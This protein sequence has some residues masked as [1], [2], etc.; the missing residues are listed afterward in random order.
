MSAV[1]R[2]PTWWLTADED[3]EEASLAADRALASLF[4][5]IE[6]APPPSFAR[7]ALVASLAVFERPIRDL[8][9]AAR[10]VTAAAAVAV[11]LGLWLALGIWNALDAG[12]DAAGV[13]DL[14]AA[15]ALVG[16]HAGERAVDSAV[17]PRL[18]T[19]LDALDAVLT[20]GRAMW[21]VASQ[22]VSAVSA[23]G[24]FDVPDLESLL[25][26]FSSDGGSAGESCR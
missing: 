23:V 9:P 11:T 13:V 14:A 2:S 3:D 6:D 16:E 17:E 10:W 1:D 7:G 20:I 25:P 12:V 21:R 18:G 4:D 26:W 8:S 19:L 24:F 5:E 15:A 22:V